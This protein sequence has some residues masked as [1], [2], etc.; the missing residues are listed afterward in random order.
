MSKTSYFC[1]SQFNAYLS[2][3]VFSGEPINYKVIY[4][5]TRGKKGYNVIHYPMFISSLLSLPRCLCIFI[6]WL[7]IQKSWPLRTFSWVLLLFTHQSP[8]ILQVFLLLITY[9]QITLFYNCFLDLHERKV[10][11]TINIIYIF[12][13][14]KNKEKSS[15][16][17]EI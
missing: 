16:D 2:I 13:L 10:E 14:I 17:N 15:F 8:H 5:L 12:I 3:P 7:Y 1:R 11:G 6:V 9:V 4:V